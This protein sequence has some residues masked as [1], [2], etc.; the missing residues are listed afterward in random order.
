MV[1]V[2]QKI[3][4]KNKLMNIKWQK[5]KIYKNFSNLGKKELNTQNNKNPY[6]RN[7][8]MTTIIKRCRGE[9]RGIRAIDGFR[10][11]LMISDS[12]IPKCPEFEVKSRIGKIFK[13]HNPIEE[14]AVKIYEIDPSFYEHYEKNIYKLIKMGVNI[15]YLELMFILINF[16]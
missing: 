9:K 3:L 4:Q 15:F 5:E 6:V 7:D 2:K 10:K 12:E 11:K 13:K 16:Y 1:F 14:Y 8:V